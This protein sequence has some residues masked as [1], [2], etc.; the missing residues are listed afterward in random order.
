MQPFVKSKLKKKFLNEGYC[1]FNID[2]AKLVDKINID[3]DNL[4]KK[5]NLRL[6]VKFT[7][8]INLLELLK[9][10]N[11]QEVAKC[12]QKIQR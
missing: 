3:I 12:Y 2:D 1:I 11:F 8:T 4:I 9:V 6:I 7:L 10:I 5:K